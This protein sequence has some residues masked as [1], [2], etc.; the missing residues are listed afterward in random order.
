MECVIQVFYSGAW[1][2]SGTFVHV[3]Y[4]H[5]WQ[6]TYVHQLYISACLVI[7]RL[8][9][10][11]YRFS[12][13]TYSCLPIECVPLIWAWRC[14]HNLCATCA[15]G[16]SCSVLQ[17]VT[18]CYSV[19]QCVAVCCIV[20]QCVFTTVHSRGAPRWPL[21]WKEAH[22]WCC[23]C[24]NIRVTVSFENTLQHTATHCNKLQHTAT[25]CNTMPLSR[26]PTWGCGLS[27]SYGHAVT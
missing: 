10:K 13:Y 20:L 16:T 4:F 9:S 24:V 5:I 14:A 18:V 6:S 1:I 22:V 2:R 3:P 25:H 26:T 27:K 12:R 21:R 7:W 11:D 23:V 8:N 15:T 19:L 17:F